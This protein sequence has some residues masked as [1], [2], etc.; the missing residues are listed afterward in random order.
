[1]KKI[2]DIVDKI[3]K[4]YQII[5]ADPPWEYNSGRCLAQT[6]LLSGNDSDPYSYMTIEELKKLPVSK[7]ADQNC[8]LFMWTTGPKLNLSFGVGKAWGFSY[9]TIGFVWEKE[10]VNPGYYT[11]SSTEICLIFRKGN[12]PTPRGKRNVKQFLSEA[13]NKHSAKPSE[14]RKRIEEMFPTQ[15]KIELF[16]RKENMLFDV[17]GFAGWDVWGNE[18]ESDI[19]LKIARSP[20]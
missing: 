6:S 1:M 4:K 19:E 7:I 15:T 12:I 14:I 8:L 11:M 9:A 13:R 5:Y 10:L 2:A 3:H 18:V 16:S 17:H 20:N